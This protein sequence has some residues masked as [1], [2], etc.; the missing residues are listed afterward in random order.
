M[1]ARNATILIVIVFA[2][3]GVVWF[4]AGRDRAPFSEPRLLLSG[5]GGEEERG[6]Q[7]NGEEIP[8]VS[9]IA[10]GLEVPWDVAFL[11]DGT[12][13]V[14]ER[15]G[16]LRIFRD[17][18]M[19][20]IIIPAIVE[21]GES[22]LLGMALHPRF[23][24]NRFIY[25][26]HTIQSESGITN[27][28]VRYV[29]ENDALERP[30]VI[31]DSIPEARFHSGGRI[32]FGPDGML[33][34]TTGDAIVPRLAQDTTSLAGKILRIHDDGSVPDDNPFG[35]EVY[36]YGHRNPQGITWDSDGRLWST[37]HG[38][39]G[40]QSGLDEINL[41]IR[42]GNYGWPESEGDTVRE[43]TIAPALHSGANETWAP[44]SAAYSD[45]SIFFGGLR[46]VTLYEAVIESGRVVSLERHF[47]GEFGRIRTVVAGPD[48]MLY[49]TTS[50]RDGRGPS[51][52]GDD[53]IIRINPIQF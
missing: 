45:G 38:R 36:S 5:E 15:P 9:V 8:P 4:V 1:N 49:L 3:L 29:L 24:E 52:D 53:K 17:G 44:A 2:L 10:E 18:V 50:N 23:E 37:E 39:S 27:R 21:R 33:Y 43:G 11:P 13:L 7:E 51:R 46:G 48:G 41:I 22:G 40:V 14:T 42:G 32:A 19:Q 6:Q 31:V 34:V 16:R 25:L 12:L 26:Y 20:T 35:N 47:V 30:E 28:V